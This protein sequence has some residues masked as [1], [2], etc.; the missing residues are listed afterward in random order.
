M[1]KVEPYY[2]VKN[3]IEMNNLIEN[4]LYK[5]IKY[6]FPKI[7]GLKVKYDKTTNKVNVSFLPG[8]YSSNEISDK[9]NEYRQSKELKE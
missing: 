5:L 2:I 8:E 4:T 7:K 6:E 3:V 9:V 1:L